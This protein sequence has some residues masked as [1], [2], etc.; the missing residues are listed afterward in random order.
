MSSTR[1][2]FSPMN[3]LGAWELDT[4]FYLPRRF[5]S[6]RDTLRDSQTKSTNV[7]YVE[8]MVN[9]SGVRRVETRHTITEQDAEV[10]C[11]RTQYCPELQI[12]EVAQKL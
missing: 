5:T 7:V 10:P 2:R 11:W 4:L 3:E 12:P 9:G 1:P 6:R 8:Q